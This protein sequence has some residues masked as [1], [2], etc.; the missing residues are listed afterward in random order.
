VSEKYQKVSYGRGAEI[1]KKRHMDGRRSEKCQK[2]SHGG[3]E[4][5][6]VPKSVTWRE[7]G[8]KSAKKRYMEERRS[9]KFQKASHGGKE[10]R[11][12]RK[13]RHMKLWNR[14]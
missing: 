1:A 12:V 7:G 13:K 14:F 9:E 3:K 2:A 4:V 10:V 8:Q 6:K 11:K 5:R